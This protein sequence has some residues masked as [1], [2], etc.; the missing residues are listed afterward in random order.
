[1]KEKLVFYKEILD[2]ESF[3]GN[4]SFIMDN[5][6][7]LFGLVKYIGTKYRFIR[8]DIYVK[9]S[10]YQ[11]ISLN[12]SI[13]L[14][15]DFFD[16][17]NISIDINKIISN[18]ILTFHRNEKKIDPF[19]NFKTSGLSYYDGNVK[20]M[21]INLEMT[22]FDSM[23]MIHEIMHYLNQPDDDR[24]IN[25]HLLTEA[26]SFGVETIYLD[27]IVN[28]KYK[29]DAID[30]LINIARSNYMQMNIGYDIY[31]IIYFYKEKKDLSKE[32]YEEMFDDDNYQ[33]ML[34]NFDEYILTRKSIF[35]YTWNVLGYPLAVYLFEEYK[36]DNNFTQKILE[37]N[38]SLFGN[39]FNLSL[40]TIGLDSLDMTKIKIEETTESFIERIKEMNAYKAK[41]EEDGNIKK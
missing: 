24:S 33:R 28:S 31:K 11:E 16:T 2:N 1:M 21:N 32:K 14:A 23:I 18:N 5:I 34:D 36:K 25:N 29:E 38:N 10:D 4:N 19:Y 37:F 17:H 26:L 35:N 27:S 8:D 20:K 6:E 41:G 15:Q 30:C 13:L 40:K 39:D 3:Y 9:N 12:E 22:I 7:T